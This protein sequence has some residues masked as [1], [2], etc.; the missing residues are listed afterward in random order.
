MLVITDLQNNV[1]AIWSDDT[2]TLSKIYPDNPDI[3]LQYNEYQM[4]DD[5]DVLSYPRKYQVVDG[6]CVIRQP[7]VEDKLEQIRKRRN[8]LL[9][10]SDFSQ[11]PDAP[12]V[13]KTAWIAYR[14]QLRDFPAVCDPNNPVWPQPP[15]P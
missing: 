5:A 6:V 13:D 4:P 1:V 8:F 9:K 3:H 7:T 12:V 2:T 14:Q 15:D 11:L 10:E